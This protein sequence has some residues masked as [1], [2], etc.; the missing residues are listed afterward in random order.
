MKILRVGDPHIKPTNVEECEK[1]MHFIHDTVLKEKPDRLE[2]LGD[3]FHTHSIL[4]LEVIEFWDAWLDILSEAV[5]T[6]VLIGNHDQSGDYSSESHA[7]SVFHRFKRKNLKIIQYPQ[8]QGIFAYVSYTHDPEKFIQTANSLAAQ[9]AKVL[10]CHQTFNGA[11]YES[12]VYAPDGIDP[13]RLNFALIIS[14]H[15]HSTQAFGNVKYPGTPKWDTASDANEKKGIWLYQH[16]D[17]TG[18]I[19]SETMISTE[20]V[21]T[22]IVS[23]IW[24]EGEAMPEFPEH[25][26]AAV[27]L[28]GS[29]DW[30]SKNKTLLKGK[31]SISS[32]ITDKAN[33]AERKA[34]VDLIDFLSNNFVT[35][36]DRPSLLKY[37]KEMGLV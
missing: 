14:G 30:V 11:K 22:P 25:A 37:A 17:T 9:G 29:S 16:D 36:M 7:L 1:L 19:I 10:V 4:R 34:G 21:V 15:I 8:N 20:H 24:K 27:E 33:R 6:V 28:I 35:T 12:G 31:V 26:K 23:V 32:R 18:A 13:A 2:I 3:L 5:E